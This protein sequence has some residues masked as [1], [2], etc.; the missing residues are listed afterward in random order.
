MIAHRVLLFD[1]NPQLRWRWVMNNE[2]TT[3][4]R[5]VETAG[6]S[7]GSGTETL[8][9]RIMRIIFPDQRKQQRIPER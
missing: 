2:Q 4:D 5:S 7:N 8:F 6:E 1:L 3:N 9:K